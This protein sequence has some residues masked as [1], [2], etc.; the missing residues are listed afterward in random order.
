MHLWHGVEHL[1]STAESW[2]KEAQSLRLKR[3]AAA[4]AM[5]MTMWPEVTCRNVRIDLTIQLPDCPGSAG[6]HPHQEVLV[7]IHVTRD[8]PSPSVLRYLVEVGLSV[9]AVQAV[10]I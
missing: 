2:I 5:V 3:L 10:A 7:F 8:G 1:I 6:P 4:V 9:V